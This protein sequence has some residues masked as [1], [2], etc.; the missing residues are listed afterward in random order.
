[1]HLLR[2]I[3]VVLSLLLQGAH[4]LRAGIPLPA[5]AVGFAGAFALLAVRR[6]WSRRAVQVVLVVGAVEWMRTAIVLAR[7]R[8]A[9]GEPYARMLVILGG[10]A[11]FT[12]LGALA[13][14]PRGT[15]RSNALARRGAGP[16]PSRTGT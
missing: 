6:P 4:L 3:A 12:L 15:A 2:M 1:M 9:F 11:L 7:E 14:T 10:V 8:A 16:A 5:I 13:A